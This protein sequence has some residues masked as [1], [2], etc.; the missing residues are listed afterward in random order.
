MA[1]RTKVKAETGSDE[2]AI[3]DR[4]VAAAQVVQP[5][6]PP[7]IVPDP[8]GFYHGAEWIRVEPDWPGLQPRDGA[9]RLWIELDA[10]LT[11]AEAS[12]IPAPFDTP[13]GQLYPHIC[14]RVRA[15]NY[16]KPDPE[17]GQMVPIPPPIE[18]GPAAFADVKPLTIVWLAYTLK[19]VHLNGGPNRKNET[20]SSAD[21]PSGANDG[22]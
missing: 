2:Q 22:A 15:W 8:D 11:F 14:H 12:A 20:S 18:I 3:V 5:Y 1:A 10:G 13:F 9:G 7:A 4:A 19:T 21:G 6:Q 17:T 16:R